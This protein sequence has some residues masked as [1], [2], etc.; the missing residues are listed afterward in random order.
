MYSGRYS[1]IFLII[2]FT[3]TGCVSRPEHKDTSIRVPGPH[4]I[5][6]DLFRPFVGIWNSTVTGQ[7][8]D[9]FEEGYKQSQSWRGRF[10]LG[11]ALFEMSGTSTVQG[12]SVEYVWLIGYDEFRDVYVAW[13]HDSE[14][15]HVRY[16][17][18]VRN[19]HSLSL[20]SET[21][22]REDAYGF[23]SKVYMSFEDP[24]RYWATIKV[25]MNGGALYIDET[26]EGRRVDSGF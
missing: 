18:V 3:L 24:S 9:Y 7:P 12:E 20:S 8:T 16:Y 2:L 26:H 13:Y 11:G 17:D 14:G 5:K 23:T 15:V 4:K 22:H 19:D 6:M 1:V 25:E 10:L 21:P